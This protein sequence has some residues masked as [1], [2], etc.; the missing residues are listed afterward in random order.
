MMQVYEAGICGNPNSSTRTPSCKKEAMFS[1]TIFQLIND[2][3]YFAVKIHLQMFNQWKS[4]SH[5]EDENEIFYESK[6]GS[7]EPGK[8]LGRDQKGWPL[9]VKG[10]VRKRNVSVNLER[11]KQGWEGPGG[12]AEELVLASRFPFSLWSLKWTINFYSLPNPWRS[13]A[14]EQA[15]TAISY[16]T[17]N[18]QAVIYQLRN[19]I[20]ITQEPVT[21]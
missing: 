11:E 5:S 9:Q 1:A 14:L 6:E 16:C 19:H 15:V 20:P 13:S 10:R 7:D 4:K 17:T 2:Y 12:R 18:F 21:F 3:K 8:E